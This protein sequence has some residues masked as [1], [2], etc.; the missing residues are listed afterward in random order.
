MTTSENNPISLTPEQADFVDACIA[1]GRYGSVNEVVG[2]GIRLLEREEQHR[3]LEKWLAGDLT[4]QEQR[5]L[6]PA[7]LERA[8]AHLQELIDEGIRSG[9]EQGWVDGA[10]AMQAIRNRAGR[11]KHAG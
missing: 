6:D 3:L 9:E 2:E 8:K 5:R 11:H 10:Q 7:L 1:S 4:E